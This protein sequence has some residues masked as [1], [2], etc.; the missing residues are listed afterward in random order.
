MMH[1]VH[2]GHAHDGAIFVMAAGGQPRRALTCVRAGWET[3]ER[4]TGKAQKRA[5]ER[6]R[7]DQSR[8]HY[9]TVAREQ[10]S[11]ISKATKFVDKSP[12]CKME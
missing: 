5:N 8:G 11:E 10:L 2:D 4:V 7:A 6:C 9:H 3:N 12:H 1:D